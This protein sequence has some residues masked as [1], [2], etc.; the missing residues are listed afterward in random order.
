MV[1]GKTSARFDALDGIRTL[2]VLAVFIYHASKPMMRGGSIGVD[3]FFT[4]S[5]LVIT[6]LLLREYEASGRIRLGR[7]YIH[8]MARLWPVLLVACAVVALTLREEAVNALRSA[9]HIMNFTR[10]GWLGDDTTGG[11]MGHTWSLAVEEQFY[12][13]WPLLLIGM[14]RVLTLRQALIATLVLT[15]ATSVLRASLEFAGAGYERLYNGPDTRFDQLLIGCALAM[16]LTLFRD[17]VARA[18]KHLIWP[19]ALFLVAHALLWGYPREDDVLSVIYRIIAPLLIALASASLFAG[20]ITREGHPLTRI[21]SRRVLSSPGKHFSYGFYLWHFPIVFILRDAL[22]NGGA[23]T[24][25]SRVILAFLLTAIASVLSAK[26]LE[27][28]VRRFVR[29]KAAGMV[30]T[31]LPRHVQPIR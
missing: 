30:A 18:V 7:F 13:V 14:L 2:A 4:L 21:L 31:S 20:L 27:E 15:A 23:M 25:I 10:G 5:G 9:V 11:A 19:S 26:C 24:A 1:N 6:L 22:E 17:R 28:P 29:S 16:M 3:V 12:L 8:R